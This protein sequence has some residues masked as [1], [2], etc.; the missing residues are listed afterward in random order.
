MHVCGD[1]CAGCVELL[2]DV[3]HTCSATEFAAL[4]MAH[5]RP[6]DAALKLAKVVTDKVAAGGG[7]GGQVG[8]AGDRWGQRGTGGGSGGQ[9]GCRVGRVWQPAITGMRSLLYK[10]C[11]YCCIRSVRGLCSQAV[12]FRPADFELVLEV[13]GVVLT[14][15]PAGQPTIRTWQEA[16]AAFA[17]ADARSDQGPGR[18]A[19]AGAGA[20]G[21]SLGAE[22]AGAGAGPSPGA[23]S[24]M[25]VIRHCSLAA[26]HASKY[27]EHG[28]GGTHRST[29]GQA[30]KA[31][32]SANP[33]S[34]RPSNCM[35]RRKG[36]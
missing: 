29:A 20:A 34:R 26:V 16:V 35:A 24:H 18:K 30:T 3:V 4:A 9:C 8:A 36:A 10:S 31:K 33:R 6:V 21:S 32:W 12:R 13:N 1:A 27:S 19:A 2:A 23:Q 28:A 7:S 14:C 11:L 22:G 5:G 25:P 15:P 17:D